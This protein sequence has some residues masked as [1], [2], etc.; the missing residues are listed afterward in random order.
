MAEPKR[1]R[2]GSDE[3][4]DTPETGFR[5]ISAQVEQARE[6]AQK[7]VE[8]DDDGNPKAQFSQA[9][10]EVADENSRRASG[11]AE[12]GGP[13]P[14]ELLVERGTTVGRGQDQPEYT[15]HLSEE[16]QTKGKAGA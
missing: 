11:S 6:D 8:F 1:R 2:S 10:A 3:E 7:P 12:G 14:P 16:E 5:D 4:S 13:W 15:S 9:A